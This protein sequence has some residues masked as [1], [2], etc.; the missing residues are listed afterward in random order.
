MTIPE[1]VLAYRGGNILIVDDF[2]MSGDFLAGLRARL[3]DEGVA[4]DRIR[5]ASVAV[6]R[7]AR[8]NHKS[9]EYYWWLADSD[10]FF[11]PWGRAR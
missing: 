5:A 11:F 10:D 1:A 9:P 7:V 8:K 2:V 3:V 4:A 6:T